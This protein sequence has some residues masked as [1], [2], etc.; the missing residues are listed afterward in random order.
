MALYFAKT[1]EVSSEQ[2][3]WFVQQFIK[4]LDITNLTGLDYD[5][6][7]EIMTTTD[8]DLLMLCIIYDSFDELL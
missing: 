8:T 6:L 7:I 1:A 3:D 5:K 4:S 2:K